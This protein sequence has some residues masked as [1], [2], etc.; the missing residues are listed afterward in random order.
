MLHEK[1]LMG[2][3]SVSHDRGIR[4]EFLLDD[5]WFALWPFSDFNHKDLYSGFCLWQSVTIVVFL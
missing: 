3:P 5:R 4:E 1:W 2:Y